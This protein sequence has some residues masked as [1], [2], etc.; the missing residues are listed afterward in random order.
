MIINVNGSYNDETKKVNFELPNIYFDRKFSY[1]VGVHQLYV[2]L[3]PT[4]NN[5]TVHENSLLCLC[6]N[7]VDRSTSNTMQALFHFCP[8]AKRKNRQF[9]TKDLITFYSLHLYE[10]DSATFLIYENFHNQQL[11]IK[12]IFIQLEILK[13][14]PYGRIQSFC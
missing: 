7:L 14:D 3:L 11:D 2:E 1:K 4:R 6:S 13:I 5:S 12:N 8:S 9:I 10:I